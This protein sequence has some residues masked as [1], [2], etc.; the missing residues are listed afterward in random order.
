MIQLIAR[1]ELVSLFGSPLAWIL[2]ALVHW[3]LAWSFLARLDSFLHI[4]PQLAMIAN[5]PGATEAIVAPVFAMAAVML[6]MATPLM[7]AR[8]IAGERHNRTLAL[9]VSAP[10]A[11]RDIVLGKFLGLMTFLCVMIVLATAL[12][13]CLL[14]GGRLDLGL[15]LGNAA[16]L[17]LVAACFASLGL[18]LSCLGTRPATAAAATLGLLLILWMLDTPGESGNLGL[19]RDLSL[20]AHYEHFNRGLIDSFSLAY[21]T[22]F[23][24]VFLTLSSHRLGGE[25]LHDGAGRALRHGM[26]ALLAILV[27]A[28]LGYLA[29]ETRVQWDIS[30]NGRNSLSQ[31]SMAVLEN[32]HGPLEAVIYAAQQDAQAGDVRRI[33]R[34][35]LARYQRA[36]PDFNVTFVDPAEHPDHARKAGIQAP[37][38]MVVSFRDRHERLDQFNEPALTHLLMRLARPGER[39]VALLGGHGERRPDGMA[40]HDMG[41]FGSRLAA[42]GYTVETFNLAA[43][44]GTPAGFDLLV[45]ASPRIELREG[46]VDRLVAYLDA[47]G[48]LL[49]LVDAGPLHGLQPLAEKLELTLMPGVVAD[50]RAR[51][52][53]LPMTV[54]LGIGYGRHPVTRD[55]GD[56]TMFP[57]ARQVIVDENET[58]RSVP[59]VEAAH[60]GW[61]ETGDAD[62]AMAFDAAYDVPGPVNVAVAL[63]RILQDREQRV[64]VVG[65][66]HFLTNTYLGYGGNLDFGINLVNWL[67]EDEDLMTIQPRSVLDAG[68][69]F[70][71]PTLAVISATLL[72]I[73]PLG[74]LMSGL[75]IGWLRGRR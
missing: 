13:A 30:Q 39:V 12:P 54:A 31:A 57:F 66:G 67:T 53:K 41:A 23:V 46:E 58:W 7:S 50:P 10:V 52:L 14:A 27:A 48:N 44:A 62:A 71:E 22:L 3:V 42:R 56:T 21:L 20:L 32:M 38:E 65:S 25:G 73:L 26:L 68:L 17:F 2:L 49:W 35:F 45:I 60:H 6:L 55:F 8:L 43:T 47:G 11:A 18:Y 36:K 63:T 69:A 28:S 61:V 75:I 1:K 40:G 37:V 64:V 9:L 59:L 74:L 51:D 33:V 34:E 16:G 72:A 19:A 24:V 4:Q 5:A 70:D 29:R 15:V